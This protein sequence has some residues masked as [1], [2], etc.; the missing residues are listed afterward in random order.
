MD[1]T[2]YE[3][4]HVVLRRGALPDYRRLMLEE[5]WPALT[6][7]GARP[8]CLL[9]GLIGLP[10]EETYGF[11]GYRDAAAWQR[12]QRDPAG[13]PPAG[14]EGDA[15]ASLQDALARRA[16]LVVSE[17]T[18]LLL[19]AP[20]RPKPQTPPDDRRRVYGLRRF[21][22]H[23][24]DWPEFVRLSNEG[25]W[26]RIEAQDAR[27]LGLF[28]DAATTDPLEVTLI[29]G[30]HGP[31]HWEAT[32][33][34]NERPADFPQELW[35]SGRRAAAARAALTLNTFVCLMTAHWPAPP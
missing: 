21:F 26:V 33:L 28:R 16:E 22:I 24:R 17:R 8:L 2:L 13:P 35:E 29:T 25:V 19:P 32:R 15:W 23:P 20:Q 6:A 12:L 5:V 4:R 31:A 27:I 11:T 18:R 3:E 7:L 34:W 1:H 14:V 30:Y 9:S 10:A